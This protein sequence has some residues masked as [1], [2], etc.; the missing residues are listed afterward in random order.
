MFDSIDFHCHLDLYPNPA[1]AFAAAARSGVYTLTVT[2]TPRA[3]PQNLVFS[4]GAEDVHPALGLHPQVIAERFNELS[5]WDDYFVQARFIG[6]VGLDAS[7]KCFRS[8]DLQKKAF[9]HILK[10]CA[11]EGDRVLSVH[12]LRAV[13]AVL[14]SIEAHLPASKGRVVLHWFTGSVSESRRAV[15]LGCY[16]SVNAEMLKSERGRAL[17]S[18]LPEERIL[19]ETDGPFTTL[20]GRP[21]SPGDVA[22]T[23]VDLARLRGIDC[24]LMGDKLRENLSSLLT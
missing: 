15:A 12:S 4:K 1:E 9:E 24:A 18:A 14:D 17:V 8:L 6:E 23:A 19:T 11:S 2:T 21:A 16:F 20:G 22:N 5:I 3:W 13:K 10:R 7:P